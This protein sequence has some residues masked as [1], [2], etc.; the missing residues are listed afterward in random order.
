MSKSKDHF[1]RIGIPHFEERR[2]T[3]PFLELCTEKS[4]PLRTAY[5]AIRESVLEHAIQTDVTDSEYLENVELGWNFVYNLNLYFQQ[6]LLN[7][8]DA[9]YTEFW[10]AIAVGEADLYQLPKKYPALPR[11][12]DSI[13][14]IIETYTRN[15]VLQ[16]NH[17]D[18]ILVEYMAFIQ[19]NATTFSLGFYGVFEKSSILGRIF[20]SKAKSARKVLLQ[21]L[22]SLWI[23]YLQCGQSMFNPSVIYAIGIELRKTTDLF[24][25]VFFDLLEVQKIGRASCRERV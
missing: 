18:Q 7:E 3:W 17:I 16:S 12:L 24:E 4:S 1:E 15:V 19:L 22:R 25:A 21:Q 5:W 13:L 11:N 14:P 23:V 10:P 6:S 20:N 2:K 8:T 9:Q